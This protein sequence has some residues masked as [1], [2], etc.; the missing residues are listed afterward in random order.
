MLS[1]LGATLLTGA[2]LRSY[3]LWYP[4]AEA[5]ARIR[6]RFRMRFDPPAP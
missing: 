4:F 3:V 5:D 6:S 2:F 1:G